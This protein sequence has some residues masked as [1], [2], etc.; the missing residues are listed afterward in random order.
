MEKRLDERQFK[1]SYNAIIRRID[2]KTKD[3][4]DEERFHNLV[5][6]AGLERVAKRL[7]SNSEDFYDVIAIGEGTTPAANGDTALETEVTRETATVTY[8]ASYKAKFEKVFTFAGP[9][10]ITEAGICD[11]LT[12]SGSTFLNHLVFSAKS[13]DTDTDL[14]VTITITFARV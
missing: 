13:V 9:E 1:M 10:T 12:P 3:I 8:E 2:N 14:S 7:I 4:I 6:N 11:S 5:V